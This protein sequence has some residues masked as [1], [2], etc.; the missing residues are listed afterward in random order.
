MR[1][2]PQDCSQGIGVPSH[3]GRYEIHHSIRDVLAQMIA[4][5]IGLCA[6]VVMIVLI[7]SGSSQE[8]IF[9]VGMLALVAAV[10]AVTIMVRLNSDA[11][12][13]W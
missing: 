3:A 6:C 12:G 2:H 8:L 13:E 5:V 4:S 9:T 11:A 7:L 10:L 1:D